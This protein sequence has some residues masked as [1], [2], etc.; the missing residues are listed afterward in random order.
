MARAVSPWTW[1]KALRDQGPEE[2]GFLLVMHTLR[3]YMDRDGFAFPSQATLAR[4]ARMHVK[5][6]RRHL[7][8]AE[9]LH[10]IGIAR[11]GRGQKGWRLFAYRCC[12]PDS[13]VLGEKDAMLADA[14][15]GVTGD[16]DPPERR[17]TIV[18]PPNPNGKDSI[19][20]PPPSVPVVKYPVK[21]PKVGKASEPSW[22]NSSVSWGHS[23]PIVGTQLQPTKSALRTLASKTHA[24]EGQGAIAPTAFE[25]EIL[26]GPRPKPED[27]KLSRIRRVLAQFPAEGDSTIRRFVSGATL[28]EVQRVRRSA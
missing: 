14:L 18:S 6:V 27:D 7:K 16:V 26:E 8:R 17:D 28:E 15:S 10:W 19:V 12:V 2:W 23:A 3:T 25:N 20:S 21:P 22:G 13:V 4:G 5:T 24:L 1:G 11:A 9:Q